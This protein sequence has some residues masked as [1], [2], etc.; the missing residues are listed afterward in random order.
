MDCVSVSLSPATVCRPFPP[1]P[2]PFL[3]GRRRRYADDPPRR[4]VGSSRPA[5]ALRNPSP[6]RAEI[7]YRIVLSE[8]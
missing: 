7:H 8:I 4:E 2:P 6:I 5:A 1:P 3:S